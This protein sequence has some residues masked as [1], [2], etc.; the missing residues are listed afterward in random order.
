MSTKIKWTKLL[1]DF[2]RRNFVAMTNSEL[3]AALYKTYT[4]NCSSRVISHRLQVL[5]LKRPT[6]VVSNNRSNTLSKNRTQL[7]T[8]KTT[9]GDSQAARDRVKMALENKSLTRQL[10]MLCGGTAEAHHNDYYK[11]LEVMWLCRKHHKQLH[12][13]LKHGNTVNESINILQGGA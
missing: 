6:E 13:L 7:Y 9:N 1:N 12:S 3:A 11:P 2:I 5:G 10:C 4:V 8:P